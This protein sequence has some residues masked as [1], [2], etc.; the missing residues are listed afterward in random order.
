[1]P[2]W[3][4]IPECGGIDVA[5]LGGRSPLPSRYKGASQNASHLIFSTDSA[6]IWPLF[7]AMSTQSVPRLS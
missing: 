1:M 5:W 3:L 4:K 7:T 6:V 2:G